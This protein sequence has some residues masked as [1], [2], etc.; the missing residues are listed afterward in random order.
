MR[1]LAKL[2]RLERAAELLDEASAASPE[3][4]SRSESA[5]F[6]RLAEAYRRAAGVPFSERERLRSELRRVLESPGGDNAT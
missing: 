3:R 6:G 4:R 5:R 2:D 1:R